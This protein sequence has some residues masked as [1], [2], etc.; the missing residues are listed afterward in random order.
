[1]P[2]N[3]KQRIRSLNRSMLPRVAGENQPS[4]SFAHQPDQAPSICRPPICP[5]SSTTMTALSASS[6]FDQKIGDRRWRWKSGLLHLHDLLTLRREN[7]HA[8]ARLPKLLHQFA[9]D[10]TFARARPAAKDRNT[11]LL[12]AARLRGLALFVIQLWI[13]RAGIRH[14]RDDNPRRPLSRFERFPIRAAKL[15]AKSLHW[16]RFVPDVA[17]LP[18]EFLEFGNGEILTPRPAQCLLPQLA[19]QHDRVAVEQMFLRPLHRFSHADAFFI[20]HRFLRDFLKLAQR[21]MLAFGQLRIPQRLQFIPAQIFL[22]SGPFRGRQLFAQVLEISAGKFRF[23][24]QQFCQRL[25]NLCVPF[26]KAVAEFFRNT[27]DLKITA[28]PVVKS[29]NRNGEVRGRVR[30]NRHSRQIFWRAE[31]HSSGALSSDFQPDQKSR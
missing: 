22:F 19:F 7:D 3:G 5:A 20:L 4:V 14:Q 11:V 30:G 2:F 1:M 28:R 15:P 8:P 17:T 21:F 12:S 16:T 26:G 25:I 6:R 13:R 10:K 29:D 31:V 24:L 18:G 27:F 23:F 9:Q